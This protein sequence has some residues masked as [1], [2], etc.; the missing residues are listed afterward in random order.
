MV[1][2]RQLRRVLSSRQL[3]VLRGV[4]E[5]LTNHAIAQRLGI[6]TSSVI[7]HL[8]AVYA[9]LEIPQDCNPRVMATLDYLTATGQLVALPTTH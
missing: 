4:A 8:S 9:A 5:G 7:N 1:N 6:A 2:E 3:D